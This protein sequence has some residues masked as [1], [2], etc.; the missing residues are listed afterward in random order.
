MKTTKRLNIEH[1]PDYYFT[2]MTNITDFD[3]R[4]LLTNEITTSNGR[5]IMFMFEISYSKENNTP[6][7]VL[8]TSSVILEKVQ[9]INI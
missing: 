5:S 4:L 8:I 3:P 9:S 6:Y 1:K 7:I 2:D